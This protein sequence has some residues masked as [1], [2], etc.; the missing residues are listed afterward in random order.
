[1]YS[2]S[3]RRCRSQ[4]QRVSHVRRT[5]VKRSYGAANGSS[6]GYARRRPNVV[7]NSQVEPRSSTQRVQENQFGP[8]FVFSQNSALSTFAPYPS[9]VKSVPNRT[10]TYTKSLRLRFKG[11]PSIER[12]Q[13][14]TIMDGPISNI[15][16]VFSMV[17]VVDRKP[18]VSQSGRLHTFDELFGARIHCHGNLSVVPASWDR[19]YI[20]HVTKRVVSLEKDTLPFILHGTTH[21]SNKR[22]R[23]WASF[24]DL[25][26]DS[27]NGV[28]GNSSKNALSV[29]YCWLSDAQSK[30]SNICIV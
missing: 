27:C 2:T 3:N 4:S 10:R 1:M 21:L 14:D 7:C 29:Y 30:A 19:Y 22:Y 9:Y 5:S 24:S 15:E 18:H 28:Y 20:R 6:S 11:T 13:G 23:C 16:G 25:E 12:G 26:R 8:E 17:I